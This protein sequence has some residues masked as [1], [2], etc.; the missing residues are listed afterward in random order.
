MHGMFGAAVFLRTCRFFHSSCAV[1]TEG[2]KF[3]QLVLQRG[4]LNPCFFCCSSLLSRCAGLRFTISEIQSSRA[5]LFSTGFNCSGLSLQRLLPQ[6]CI[7][8]MLE[9]AVL[10]QRPGSFPAGAV[11]DQTF[12]WMCGQRDRIS[13]E[14]GI[15]HPSSLYCFFF[16][17]PDIKSSTSP[18]DSRS[19]GNLS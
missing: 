7:C 9:K 5:F 2:E 13:A 14:I 4:S 10:S 8:W 12:V 15:F 6:W 16:T 17:N 11:W 3:W 18:S 1:L 19:F